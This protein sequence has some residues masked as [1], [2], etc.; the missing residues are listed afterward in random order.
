[1]TNTLK[2]FDC[3]LYSNHEKHEDIVQEQEHAQTIKSLQYIESI[4]DEFTAFFGADVGVSVLSALSA[5]GEKK[6]GSLYG[7]DRILAEKDFKSSYNIMR[8]KA[9]STAMS[10]LKKNKALDVDDLLIKQYEKKDLQYNKTLEKQ[11][12]KNKKKIEKISAR[13]AQGN[14]RDKAKARD[15]LKTFLINNDIE[16]MRFAKK[17]KQT[18]KRFLRNDMKQ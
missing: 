12:E 9:Y 14:W 16:G 5:G 8:L 1:M 13:I 15:E 2:D 4:V 7:F 17:K 3:G 11:K 6:D 10:F 18:E